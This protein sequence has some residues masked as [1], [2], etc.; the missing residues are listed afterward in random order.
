MG[1]SYDRIDIQMESRMNTTPTEADI[2]RELAQL[3]TLREAIATAIVGQQD[4]QA[5]RAQRRVAVARAEQ[6]R[7]VV[8]Q[9]RLALQT[10]LEKHPWLVEEIPKVA[11][12]L[13]RDLA[14][15]EQISATVPRLGTPEG[16]Q[17]Q[18]GREYV[19]NGTGWFELKY[20]DMLRAANRET[21]PAMA[22]GGE[23]RDVRIAEYHVGRGQP[24]RAE[25][26]APLPVLQPC[27]GVGETPRLARLRQ[28]PERTVNARPPR[29]VQAPTRN[30]DGS[31]T[32]RSGG[33]D[34]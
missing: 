2:Q 13:A 28:G 33:Q 15:L 16:W 23:R 10:M 34:R 12:G 5:A 3:G 18:F 20:V 4:V 11:G 8:E 9:L 19:P 7:V 22:P 21:D 27:A 1:R 14:I 17:G 25:S 31:G 32:P 29:S 26:R 24:R 30:T 6:Q